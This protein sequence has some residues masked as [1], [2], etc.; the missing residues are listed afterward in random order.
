MT[1]LGPDPEL[2]EL[3]AIASQPGAAAQELHSDDTWSAEHARLVT[4]FLTL[5]DVGEERA[6][7]TW[8]IP[9]THGKPKGP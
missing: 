7:P 6:G 8:F 9:D 3:T 4:M 2:C 5:H 1:A